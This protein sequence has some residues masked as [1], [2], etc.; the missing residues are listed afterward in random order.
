MYAIQTQSPESRKRYAKEFQH[1]LHVEDLA[2]NFARSGD[3]D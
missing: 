2:A 3:I 1:A